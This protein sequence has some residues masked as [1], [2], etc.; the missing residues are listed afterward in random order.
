MVDGY[1][2][3]YLYRTL[4]LDVEIF[5]GEDRWVWALGFG[6]WDL[7]FEYGYLLG[8][9]ERGLWRD[10]LRDLRRVDREERR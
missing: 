4:T 3:R 10:M 2:V 5:G 1:R 6:V 7:G 8:G 9:F